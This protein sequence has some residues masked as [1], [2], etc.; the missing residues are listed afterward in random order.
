VD[1]AEGC[2][3]V[4][5]PVAFISYRRI[6]EVEQRTSLI[7]RSVILLDREL[8]SKVAIVTGASSGIGRATARLF[9]NQGAKVV[10]VGRNQIGLDEVLRSLSEEAVAVPADVTV[11]SD[12]ERIVRDG[13][14]RFGK[15]DILINAAGI[16]A[17]GTIENT[18]IQQW[19]NMFQINVRSVFYLMHLAMPH[20]VKTKGNVV[21]VSSV[22][23]QRSFPNV[24]AYCASKAALDHLTRC[25]ALEM[26]S[27]GVRVNAVCPGVT[28]TQLHRRGGMDEIAYQKFLEHSKE[29][30]PLGRVGN[31]EE[32]ADLILFLASP[33]ANWITGVTYLIDGGR[34]QTCLR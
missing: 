25:A 15:L 16:I 26:A 18:T 34:G 10:L 7:L 8:E 23:G 20:L 9:A 1:E 2:I 6:L 5:L 31:A 28:I 11:D 4:V 12:C 21:N 3:E 14:S 33:R 17:N 32:I 13:I 27:K 24:L 29:T 19:D 22:N 30:H